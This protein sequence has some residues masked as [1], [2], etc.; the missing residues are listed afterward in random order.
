MA[1]T[2]KSKTADD[3]LVSSIFKI[4]LQRDHFESVVVEDCFLVANE[5]SCDY[6]N[7]ILASPLLTNTLTMSS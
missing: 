1:S 7:F 4:C 5:E 6:L 3:D 2:M